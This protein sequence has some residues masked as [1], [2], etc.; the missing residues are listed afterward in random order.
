MVLNL[1]L[2]GSIFGGFDVHLGSIL[3]HGP[4]SKIDKNLMFLK[5]FRYSGGVAC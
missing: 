4:D 3:A 1:G 5:V 2:L